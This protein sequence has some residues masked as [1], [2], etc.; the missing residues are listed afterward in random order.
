LAVYSTVTQSE[1][2]EKMSE[3]EFEVI[4]AQAYT[5]LNPLQFFFCYLKFLWG[6]EGVN[7]PRIYLKQAKG[8]LFFGRFHDFYD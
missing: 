3:V 8:K 5:V 1:H 4:V 6:G 2:R 7:D